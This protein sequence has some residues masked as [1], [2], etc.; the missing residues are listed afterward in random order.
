MPANLV[1]GECGQSGEVVSSRWLLLHCYLGIPV[2]NSILFLILIFI[3][4]TNKKKKHSLPPFMLL[5]SLASP[6][7]LLFPS[8]F[9]FLFYFAFYVFKSHNWILLAF[10]LFQ[11]SFSFFFSFAIVVAFSLTFVVIYF[12]MLMIYNL[13]D[14]RFEELE[15]FTCGTRMLCFSKFQHNGIIYIISTWK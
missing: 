5:F 7:S 2:P 10:F 8:H 1:H 6:R 15:P 14:T 4:N 9:H 11:F 3:F 13:H 12:Y